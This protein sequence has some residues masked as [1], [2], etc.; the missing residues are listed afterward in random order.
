MLPLCL[1]FKFTVLKT[2]LCFS[3]PES[4]GSLNGKRDLSTFTLRFMESEKA[5]K[6]LHRYV[7]LWQIRSLALISSQ[8]T[9]LLY[10]LK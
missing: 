3:M 2:L 7:G 5:R 8:A 9:K 10:D 6:P 1:G 4:R